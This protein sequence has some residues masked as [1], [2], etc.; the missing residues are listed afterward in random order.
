MPE[1]PKYAPTSTAEVGANGAVR[2]FLELFAIFSLGFWGFVTW[3]LPLNFVFGIG[4]PL[5]AA[6]LWGL[7]RSPKARFALPPV[8]RVI[9]EVLVMGGAALAWVA[10]GRGWVG[11]VF[12][13]L[14]LASGALN[15]RSEIAREKR[16]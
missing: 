10:I 13:V 6:I 12:G 16:A 2:F 8:G 15:L 5:V 7:F 4:T 9:V 14:A 11:I 3:P 1:T